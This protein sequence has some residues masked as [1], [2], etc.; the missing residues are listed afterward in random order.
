MKKKIF[1]FFNLPDMKF[2]PMV[3]KLLKIIKN[4][5]IMI[6]FDILIFF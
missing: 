6:L 4:N 5:N 2:S 1:D 3:E